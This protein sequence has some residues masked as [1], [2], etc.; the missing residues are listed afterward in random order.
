MRIALGIEYL[1]AAYC[2]WQK[3]Q[4]CLGVQFYLEQALAKIACAPIE[5]FCAG[6]TDKG[7]HALG[8]VVHFDSPVER[9][10]SAWVQGVNSHLPPDI[11]VLWQRNVNDDF[12]ARF[13]AQ[14]RRYRYLLLNQS[15]RSGVF[16][17]HYAW[18]GYALDVSAMNAA[19]QLLLGEHD[20]SSFRAAECQAKH[21]RRSVL[22]ASCYRQ[23]DLVVFDIEANAFLHHM[24]RNMVGSLLWVGRGNKPVEWIAEL[25]AAR[26]RKLAAPT[27]EAQGLYLT[28][29]R[30]PAPWDDFPVPEQKPSVSDC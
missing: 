21:P 6:R 9:P 18:S 29:V 16:H 24:V 28:Q 23:G 22:E 20:F 13:S 8:Q 19:M 1:G 12:H 17:Q 30:Y 27:A 10:T 11:R 15:V 25:L 5:V 2:G 4:D 26:D 7:V 3:Q 14:A